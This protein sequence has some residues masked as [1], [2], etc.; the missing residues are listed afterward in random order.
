MSIQSLSGEVREATVG[1]FWRDK[2]IV[3]DPFDR[4]GV[5][6]IPL[7]CDVLEENDYKDIL[8][9]TTK[10]LVQEADAENGMLT[11]VPRE[12]E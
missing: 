4:A 7:D 12:E 3:Y 6:E 11:I 8:P 10:V 2:V 9:G 1:Y 5:E